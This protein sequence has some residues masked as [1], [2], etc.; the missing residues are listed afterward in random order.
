MSH[1]EKLLRRFDV[2]FIKSISV[3]PSGNETNS[4]PCVPF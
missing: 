4:A 2:S 3:V 1:V